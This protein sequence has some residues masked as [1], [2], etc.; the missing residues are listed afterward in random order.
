MNNPSKWKL[1]QRYISG[2]CSQEGRQKVERWMQEDPE[3]R[4]LVKELEQIWELS[5]EED[6]EVNVQEAWEKFRHREIDS[7]KRED[8]ISTRKKPR[9][10]VSYLYRAAAVILIAALSGYLVWQY[11]ESSTR[12]NATQQG[13]FYV[14]QDLVTKQS[15]KARVKFSDGTSV[16]LNAASSLRFPKKF[17]GPRREVYLDGEAYFEVAHNPERPFIVHTHGAEVEVLGTKFNVRAWDEDADMG[18]TVRQGKVSVAAKSMETGKYEKTIL[19][20]GQYSRIEKG[21]GP[22]PARNVDINKYLLWLN[23]GMHFENAPFSQVVSQLERRFKVRVIV[24]DKQLLEV[25]FTGTLKDADLDK[26]LK[27]ISASMEID[28]RREGSK[29]EF[30]SALNK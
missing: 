22:S 21:K 6:F 29:I 28:Y 19:T 27:V 24:L 17:N 4:R 8:Y 25:P 15:E 10:L 9:K 16:I 20:R 18:V 30:R 11:K 26:M 1:I 23:G 5:P 3:H 2:R 12:Q 7:K 14:M 13:D